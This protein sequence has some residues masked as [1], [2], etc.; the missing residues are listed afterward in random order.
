MARSELMG[1]PNVAKNVS[2][3]VMLTAKFNTISMNTFKFITKF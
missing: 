3:D 1:E 2:P